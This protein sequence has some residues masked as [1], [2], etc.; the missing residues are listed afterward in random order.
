MNLPLPEL[1]YADKFHINNI[2][3]FSSITY[4]LL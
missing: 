4:I 1:A 2:D 3:I